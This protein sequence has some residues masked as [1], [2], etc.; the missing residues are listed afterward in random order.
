[1]NTHVITVQR[2]NELRRR[3][4]GGGRGGGEGVE[5]G[6]GEWTTHANKSSGRIDYFLWLFYT[7]FFLFSADERERQRQ[8]DRQTDRNRDKQDK[9]R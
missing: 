6:G 5:G 1:M 8:T 7:L 2:R 9:Q 4:G 3:G